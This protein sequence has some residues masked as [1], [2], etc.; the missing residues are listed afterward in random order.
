M[1]DFLC[2][3]NFWSFIFITP[4]PTPL[5]Q[6]LKGDGKLLFKRPWPKNGEHLP[7]S[8]GMRNIL[9]EYL[10]MLNKGLQVYCS[11]KGHLILKENLSENS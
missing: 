4:V 5:F 7:L 10:V 9:K 6:H 11:V 2:I 3:Y 1:N 8:D